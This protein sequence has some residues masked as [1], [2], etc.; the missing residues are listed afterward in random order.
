MDLHFLNN[1]MSKEKIKEQIKLK[2]EYDAKFL[3]N[4]EVK[5][6]RNPNSV[7]VDPDKNIYVADTLNHRIQKYVKGSNE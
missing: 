1:K 4:Y 7:F 6:L 5:N 3:K 2:Y